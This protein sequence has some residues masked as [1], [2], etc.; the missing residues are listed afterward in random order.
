MKIKEGVKVPSRITAD[1]MVQGRVYFVARVL[2][3]AVG[4]GWQVGDV[5]FPVA[6]KYIVDLDALDSFPK[7]GEWWKHIQVEELPRGSTLVHDV[8]R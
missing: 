7:S 6:E 2:S 5:L 1:Q 4:S 3:K 8:E